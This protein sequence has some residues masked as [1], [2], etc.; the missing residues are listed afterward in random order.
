MIL[1]GHLLTLIGTIVTLV[2]M[3]FIISL[4]PVEVPSPESIASIVAVFS[5]EV[6][7]EPMERRMF[8]ASV[9]T[10]PG[11]IWGWH[12]LWN[13]IISGMTVAGVHRICGR[14]L[15][16]VVIGLLWYGYL[17]RDEGRLFVE[18]LASGGIWYACCGIVAIGLCLGLLRHDA[19]LLSW[20]NKFFWGVVTALLFSI[21]AYSLYD[22]TTVSDIHMYTVHF[23]VIFHSMVQVFLGKALLVDFVH[24]YGL[25]PHFLEPLFRLVGLDFLSF[26]VLIGILT[27]VSFL[28]LLRTMFLITG[29]RT[30]VLLGFLA[31]VTGG[32]LSKIMMGYDPYFQYF[33]LRTIFP[34]ATACLIAE[35]L[36][37][38]SS[39]LFYCLYGVASCAILWNPETG[40]IALIAVLLTTL[41]DQYSL[42]GLSSGLR[43]MAKGLAVFV[44][45]IILFSGYM[46]FRYGVLP[47]Y[48]EML[49][50]SRIF[51]GIGFF[52]IPM[53]PLHPWNIVAVIYIAGLTWGLGALVNRTVTYRT[54][55]VTFLSLLGIGLFAYYQGRSHI[56]VLVL[57][58][59]P[60]YMLL[61]VFT[62]TLFSL[63]K[64]IRSARV[65]ALCGI[66]LMVF[67]SGGIYNAVN[68]LYFGE[69]GITDR[70]AL[71]RDGLESKVMR[72]ANFIK[73]RTSPGEEV[74]ILSGHSGLFHLVSRTTNP[75]RIPSIMEVVLQ[76]DFQRLLDYVDRGPCSKLFVDGG[77]YKTA[78]YKKLR[79]ILTEK[80]A[81]G[82][83]S[84]DRN[85]GMYVRVR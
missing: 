81:Y 25:Y 3:C 83:V 77:V 7:P 66:T 50:Y 80:Y 40:I 67:V 39:A 52:M 70:F 74:L 21:F 35:Y 24:Q 26:T 6:S 37:N 10:L 5:E 84:I 54:T 82:G 14:L 31:L 51:Y 71:Y 4:F 20:I 15:C 41:Y 29:N 68:V 69:A 60:A 44:C 47:E 63:G 38:R 57:C 46:Y 36:K 56:E 30:I 73:E 33:P 23:N 13:K 49:R 59:Y 85:I 11:I 27:V 1:L 34:A 64:K 45:V 28:L 2:A 55:M 12:L 72:R 76:D 18:L 32:Y 58:T 61:T 75:V 9:V 53:V 8:L 48:G 22:R 78:D 42:H 43:H 19:R 17:V 62:D 65:A 79:K 16:G